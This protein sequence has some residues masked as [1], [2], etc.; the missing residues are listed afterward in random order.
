MGFA[1]V[2]HYVENLKRRCGTAVSASG[3]RNS[4][5]LQ[6]G[7]TAKHA[8]CAQESDDRKTMWI[9]MEVKGGKGGGG[10]VGNSR[11]LKTEG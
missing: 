3:C 10:S 11:L 9:P 1:G 7:R 5:V 4:V 6:G 2:Q 8:K